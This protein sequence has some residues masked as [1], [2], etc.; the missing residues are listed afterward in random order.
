MLLRTQ[1]VRDRPVPLWKVG[2]PGG[3]QSFGPPFDWLELL[4]RIDESLMR[5]VFRGVAHQR[6]PFVLQN[7]I[8]VESADAP[9]WVADFDKAWEYGG[10]PKVMLALESSR[11]QRTY[12][13]VPANINVYMGALSA[14]AVGRAPI[15]TFRPS[16]RR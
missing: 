6:L 10:W 3:E 7:G 15:D 9:I 2:V 4:L 1:L 14:S 12:R 16:L 5:C 8:D 11:L 13:E